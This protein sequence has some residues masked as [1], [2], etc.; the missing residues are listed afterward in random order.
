MEINIYRTVH[1]DSIYDQMLILNADW[2][3][4]DLFNWSPA[5]TL[6]EKSRYAITYS[7][8]YE[9]W[10]VYGNYLG[11][12]SL[13]DLGQG[14]YGK[15]WSMHFASRRHTGPVVLIRGWR[16][17]KRLVN[18]MGGGLIVAYIPTRR[19][20]IFRLASIMGFR[21]FGQNGIFST[22]NTG[23]SKAAKAGT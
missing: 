6:R 4:H 1:E 13:L 12:F 16:I 15:R 14:R 2:P 10:D 20:D 9:V 21:K 7:Q 11:Y 8:W 23:D 5:D 19:A 17:L 18:S 22:K 3:Q